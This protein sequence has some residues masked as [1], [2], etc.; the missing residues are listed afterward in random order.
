MLTP[1]VPALN[2]EEATSLSP[3]P[4]RCRRRATRYGESYTAPFTRVLFAAA[5]KD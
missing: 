2:R 4:T 1:G 3:A 5:L